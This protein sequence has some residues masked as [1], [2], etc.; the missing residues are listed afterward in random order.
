[1][2]CRL[3]SIIVIAGASLPAAAQSFNIEWG[4]PETSPPASYAA[5]GLAGF[6]NT[7]DSMPSG[8]AMPLMGLDGGATL[9]TIRNIGFD[10]V[11]SADIPGTSGGDEALLDDCFTSFNDPIDGCLFID[12]IEPGEYMVIMYGL[13]PDDDLL[14]SRLRIDQNAEDPVLVGGAWSGAHESGI[15]Y[16][17]QMATV[18]LD[19]NLDVHSGLLGG[20]IRSV[21]NGM[22][23]VSLDDLGCNGADLADPLGQLDFSDIVA[24][25]NA[26]S[27][28]Q[29][30]ADLA[31]PIGQW[32][33]SDVV[34]FLGLFAGGCP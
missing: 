22:Q 33:F 2:N 1:M 15:T 11:E 25:L 18:G 7:F 9:V 16:M 29:P 32:D 12:N 4:S 27:A 13:A 6:W 5:E 24:F 26:F 3:A 20:D 30:G 21:L 28:Q 10:V 8:V 17:A 34:A 19:R 23:I 31:E 14:K